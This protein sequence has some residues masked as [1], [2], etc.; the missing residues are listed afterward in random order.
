MY[1]WG[2]NGN[3]SFCGERISDVDNRK[4]TNNGKC[5]LIFCNGYCVEDSS[6]CPITYIDTR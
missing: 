5:E 6:N 2:K 3:I 4:F 1:N